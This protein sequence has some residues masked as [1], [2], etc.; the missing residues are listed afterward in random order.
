[1]RSGHQVDA[2]LSAPHCQVAIEADGPTHYNA[3]IHAGPNVQLNAKDCTPNG[4]TQLRNWTLTKLGLRV[5]VVPYFDVL[6]TDGRYA[7]DG[8]EA[9]SNATVMALLNER[10]GAALAAGPGSAETVSPLLAAPS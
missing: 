5:V 8:M 6:W 4:S 3:C 9:T 7:F 1:M 2:L 10:V